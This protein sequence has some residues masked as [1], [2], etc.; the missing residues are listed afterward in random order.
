MQLLV[1]FSSSKPT[2]I[3]ICEG[4]QAIPR[5]VL[6]LTFGVPEE[7]FDGLKLNVQFIAPQE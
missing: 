2:D 3:G 4:F 5:K 1:I 6:G 7:R